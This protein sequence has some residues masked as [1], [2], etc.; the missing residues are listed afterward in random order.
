MTA[1]QETPAPNSAGSLKKAFR[2]VDVQN[3]AVTINTADIHAAY[4]ILSSGFKSMLFY[5]KLADLPMRTRGFIR[6]THIGILF[7]VQVKQ[8][9]VRNI[10]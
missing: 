5:C 7:S 8:H 9:P 2:P 1:A 6:E 10:K 3:M 4:L